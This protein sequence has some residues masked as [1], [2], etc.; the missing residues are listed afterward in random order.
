ME[1]KRALSVAEFN[2][3][4]LV[5]LHLEDLLLVECNYWKKEVYNSLDQIR[6]G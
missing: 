4:G 1:D 6:R 5:K 2:F 3:K